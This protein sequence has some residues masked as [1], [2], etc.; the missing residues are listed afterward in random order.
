MRT[1]ALVL[2]LLPLPVS[3]ATETPPVLI[4]APRPFGYVIGDRVPLAAEF[5]LPAGCEPLPAALPQPGRVDYW[6]ELRS[7]VLQPLGSGRFRLERVYQTFFAPLEVKTLTIRAVSIAYRCQGVSQPLPIPAW[8]FTMAPI[9]PVAVGKGHDDSYMRPDRPPEPPSLARHLGP[10]SGWSLIAVA[11][12]LTLAWLNGWL[13]RS[14][15]RQAFA[16]VFRWLRA[17][18]RQPLAGPRLLEAYARVHQA[19]NATY[20]KPLFATKMDDFV[21]AHPSWGQIRPQIEAFFQASYAV[22]FG[23]DAGRSPADYPPERLLELA[24][25]CRQRERRA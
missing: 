10:L 21:S 7:A 12:G 19:F 16:A 5:V 3:A 11:C 14:R 13:P 15:R 1:P 18:L 17:E 8:N 23:S 22:H 6:L 25:L 9:R 24:T 4:D 20:G 2:A